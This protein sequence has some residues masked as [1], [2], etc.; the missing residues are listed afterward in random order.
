MSTSFWDDIFTKVGEGIYNIS[1]DL[2][3]NHIKKIL[4]VGG[5]TEDVNFNKLGW[6]LMNLEQIERLYREDAR[7]EVSLEKYMKAHK[8]AGFTKSDNK[9]KIFD[10]LFKVKYKQ[11]TGELNGRLQAEHS[12]SG[13]GMVREIRHLIFAD[14]YFDV[15]VSNCHPVITEWICDNLGIECVALKR[16]IK[17]RESLF[18]EI[19]NYSVEHG[20]EELERGYLKIYMLMISYGCGKGKINEIKEEHRHPFINEYVNCM[21]EIGEKVMKCFYSFYK[22]NKERRIAKEKA[23]NYN[24]SGMSHL[25]QYVENQ[26]LLKM[27]T[28]VSKLHENGKSVLCFDGIMIHKDV[29]TTEFNQDSYIRMCESYFHSK[30]LE[31]FKLEVK[32]MTYGNMLMENLK[33]KGCPYI[34]SENYV[35]EWFA[36]CINSRKKELKKYKEMFK[37]L[38]MISILTEEHKDILKKEVGF[39][40]KD[41]QNSGRMA[42]HFREKLENSYWDIDEFKLFY[43]AFGHMYY[44]KLESNKKQY[45][46]NIDKAGYEMGD[47]AD[48]NVTISAYKE[49]KIA[50]G[51]SEFILECIGGNLDLLLTKRFCKL[52]RKYNK[53][54]FHPYTPFQPIDKSIVSVDDFNVFSG[55]KVSGEGQWLNVD[56]VDMSLVEPWLYHLKE[57]L[58]A[59][60]LKGYEWMLRWIQIIFREPRTRTKKVPVFV[61]EGEQVGGKGT[62]FNKFLSAL[63]LGDEKLSGTQEGLDFLVDNFNAQLE[64]RILTIC[65]EATT[66]DGGFGNIHSKLKSSVTEN[67]V[68]INDKHTKR[69]V[70][71]NFNNFVILS[72]YDNCV[73]VNDR[74][75]RFAL[76]KTSEKPIMEKGG[77]I[78]YFNWLYKYITKEAAL[79]FY[80]Y[81]Y[82]LD[83]SHVDIKDRAINDFYASTVEATASSQVKFAKEVISI[84]KDKLSPIKEE[85]DDDDKLVMDE[86]GFDTREWILMLE[87]NLTYRP[88]KKDYTIKKQS[89]YNVYRLWCTDEGIRKPVEFKGAFTTELKKYMGEIMIRNAHFYSIS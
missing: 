74:E 78:A 68:C 47:I 77:K 57:S 7:N 20:G 17:E 12:I 45:I 62:F 66:A 70:V 43:E 15:D 41:K 19:S 2:S 67:K 18:K 86:Q 28:M 13:Q 50:S 6:A 37:D 82:H 59:G 9:L 84:V 33:D 36:E 21:K 10:N 64:G 71:D 52:V 16:Y 31:K 4:E 61:S 14:K 79:H 38:S 11:T 44:A 51:D 27:Y 32:E 88:R 23:Y 22:L 46:L 34:E 39:I 1:P 73:K 3:L 48:A 80:Y 30:G 29:F 8:K 63:I 53:F 55:Y 26:I 89:L 54:V 81:V 76:F 83:L 85:L 69:K 42:K 65:E 87:S 49:K 60:S 5:L 56:E 58:C 24:G 25:C 35:E 40:N 75:E 72:N